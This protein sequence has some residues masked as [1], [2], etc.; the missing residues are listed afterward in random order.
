MPKDAKE[1][2]SC[3]AFAKD[4]MCK[5][6]KR[7]YEQVGVERTGESIEREVREVQERIYKEKSANI[8]KD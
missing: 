4:A 2:E 8:Y 6:F 1:I 3:E 5:D 7:H